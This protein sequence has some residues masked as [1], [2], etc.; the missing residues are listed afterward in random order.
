[1]S[2]HERFGH[3][4]LTEHESK[5]LLREYDIPVL[6]ESLA[7][8]PE[9]AQD[10]AEEIGLPIIMKVESRDI[11]HKT[12]AGGVIKVEE[13][14]D[15]RQAYEDIED[16]ITEYDPEASVDGVLV[17]EVLEGNEFIVGL[18][19]DPQFGTVLM[20]GLG[21]IYVEVFEDVRFS[22]VPADEW[23]I[24]TMIEELEA[25]PLLDGVRGQPPADMDRLVE[26]LGRISDMA[27][28]EPEIEE[29][30]INP[31]FIHGDRIHAADALI[32]LGDTDA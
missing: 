29:L 16:N 9:E 15:I 19:D 28:Q 18:N 3:S 5:Q 12:E 11:Q 25:R 31:L 23:D 26:V 14:D 13:M 1:M 6:E 20:F 22:V 32:K 27:Q 24:R 2:L 17:G 7:T 30:D 10:I 4:Q 8:T 21:G